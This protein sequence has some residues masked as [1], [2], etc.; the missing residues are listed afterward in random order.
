MNGSRPKF[1][2]DTSCLVPLL[3]PWHD[4]HRATLSAWQ[5]L[6]QDH[7]PLVVAAHALLEC[8][9]VLT[10]MPPPFRMPPGEVAQALT[11]TLSEGVQTSGLA[12]ETAWSALYGLSRRGIAGGRIYDAVI[13]HS[14]RQAGATVLLTWNVRDFL[15]VAPPGLD[16][17]EP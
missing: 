2:V 12:P 15:L 16:I 6:R 10:R 1:G 17:R 4:L 9:S 8:F 7:T 11:E 14:V 13:A 3:C 5:R